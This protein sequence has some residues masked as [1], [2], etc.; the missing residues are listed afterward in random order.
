MKLLIY[1]NRKQDD[2]IW[3]IDTP[4]QRAQAFLA[5]FKYLRDEWQVYEDVEKQDADLKAKADTGDTQ[6][7]EILL[8]RRKSYEYEEWC[9]AETEN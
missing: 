9:Y 6:S 3:V 1:G 8:R 7:A 2:M 5:L 4:E